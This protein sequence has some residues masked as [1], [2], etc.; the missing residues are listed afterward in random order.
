[1]VL[2]RENRCPLSKRPVEGTGRLLLLSNFSN[3]GSDCSIVM[4]SMQ[5][6]LSRHSPDKLRPNLSEGRK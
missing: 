4:G 5:S 2:V 1:M 6:P 3:L